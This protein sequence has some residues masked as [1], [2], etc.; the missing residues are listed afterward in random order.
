MKIQSHR[1]E[2]E[3]VNGGWTRHTRED[4]RNNQRGRKSPSSLSTF[5]VRRNM[6]QLQLHTCEDSSVSLSD[7]GPEPLGLLFSVRAPSGFSERG[8]LRQ[9][10]LVAEEGR[11]VFAEIYTRNYR[12]IGNVGFD[13]EQ[14]NY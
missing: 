8:Q 3:Y 5:K 1:E 12:I 7:L 4:G 2:K 10:D 13:K 14:T 6:K 9:P 11:H